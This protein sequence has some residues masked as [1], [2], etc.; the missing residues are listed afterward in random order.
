MSA[1]YCFRDYLKR[2][3]IKGVKVSSAGIV[4]K[5]QKMRVSIIPT[6]LNKKVDPR[7]HI[8]RKLNKKIYDEN[9][10]IIVMAK[11]HYDFISKRFG[12]GKIV[13]YK[14]I[15]YGREDSLKDI[16]EVFP[17]YIK[18]PKVTKTYS[19]FVVNCIYDHTEKF[20]KKLQKYILFREFALGIVKKNHGLSFIRLYETRNTLA[21]MSIDIPSTEDGHIIVIPKKIYLNLESIPEKEFNELMKTVRFM[22][23]A[24][25]E[26]HGGY[27]LLLNGGRDAGHSMD[28]V[29]FHVIPR[30]KD[31]NIRLETW[32]RKTL[33]EKNFK[34][35]NDKMLKAVKKLKSKGY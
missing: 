26:S 21:F 17:D 28:H 12:N 7:Q 31:D 19:D 33:K 25:L 16:G 5:K 13:L 23:K 22:G 30:K 15:L 11:N 9:D 20:W 24:I 35:M 29:H 32:R 4:A 3:N 8:Q 14:D 18:R 10:L 1:E 27:N 6:L 2:K 34:E